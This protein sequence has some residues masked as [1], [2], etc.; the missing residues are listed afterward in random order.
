MI[1]GMHELLADIGSYRGV[2]ERLPVVAIDR[3]FPPTGPGEGLLRTKFDG[4]DLEQG[5]RYFERWIEG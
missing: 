5:L 4:L 2:G 3:A 1:D